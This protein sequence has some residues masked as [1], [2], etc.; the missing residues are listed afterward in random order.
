LDAPSKILVGMTGVLMRALGQL[1]IVK[2]PCCA[3]RRDACKLRGK[4]VELP[5]LLSCLY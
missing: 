1:K 5:S 3:E 4:L 2:W